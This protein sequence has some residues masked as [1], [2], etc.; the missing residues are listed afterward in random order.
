MFK[1]KAFNPLVLQQCSQGVQRVIERLRTTFIESRRKKLYLDTAK[2]N[3]EVAPVVLRNENTDTP[4]LPTPVGRR[5][6]DISATS[7]RQK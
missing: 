6:F 4:V 2:V 1:L 7:L 5:D 3:A